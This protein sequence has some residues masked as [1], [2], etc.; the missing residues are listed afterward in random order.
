MKQA[1]DI[2][3]A[4]SGRKNRVVA[5]MV[6]LIKE[7]QL[8][9]EEF[10]ECGKHAREMM[11]LNRP[12]RKNVMKPIPSLDEVKKFLGIIERADTSDALMIKLL[13][14][15]G[16]RSVELTRIRIEDIDTTPG[17]ERIFMHRKGG[18]DKWFVVPGKL[19]SLL[20]MYL[21]GCEKQVYLFESGYHRAYTTRA[22]RSKIQKYREQAGIGDVLHAHNFRH[23]LLTLLAAEGWTDSELQL[24]SGHASRT[25]LDKYT[26]LNPE[27]I[28]VK[29]N[30]SLDRVM[31]GLS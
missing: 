18:Q 14:F 1:I 15:L 30:G 23:M 19:S 11:Q 17:A 26:H 4:G 12:R 6:E 24:V 10:V 2:R 3:V 13:L 29:L 27:L 7:H 5:A 28:R 25:N 8:S 16:I 21:S 31:G 20:R 22:I 9:Y